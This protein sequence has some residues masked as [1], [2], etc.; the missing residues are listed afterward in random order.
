[1]ISLWRRKLSPP[2]VFIAYREQNPRFFD[3]THVYIS[4]T[5]SPSL[6]SCSFIPLWIFTFTS[7]DQTRE[8]DKWGFRKS[9]LTTPSLKWTVYYQSSI[10]FV[11]WLCFKNYMELM[12][13]SSFLEFDVFLFTWFS[14]YWESSLNYWCVLLSS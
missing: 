9:G 6:L 1:M 13:F 7:I 3:S 8:R 12:G 5:P 11:V 14:Y 2:T 4:H 10:I